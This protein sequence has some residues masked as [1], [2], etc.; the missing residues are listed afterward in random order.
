[1][2]HA[3]DV[4]VQLRVVAGPADRQVESVLAAVLGEAVTNVLRHSKATCCAMNSPPSATR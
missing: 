1:M 3:A 2:L 4:E